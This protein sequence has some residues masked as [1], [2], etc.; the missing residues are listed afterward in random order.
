DRAL[1]GR[2]NAEASIISLIDDTRWHLGLVFHRYIDGDARKLEISINGLHVAPI[3]PFMS[4]NKK[5][6][7]LPK[8]VLKFGVSLITIQPYVLP[9]MKQMRRDDIAAAQA[10]GERLRRNQGCYVYRNKRLV[11]AGSWFRIGELA[12]L[13]K[14]ARVRIDIGNEQ[15]AA[16]DLDIKKS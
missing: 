7:A 10:L 1:A 9:H 13:S 15:D 2:N 11:A 6:Q 14:L 4:G 5:T 12:E 3:D 8:K 16:W